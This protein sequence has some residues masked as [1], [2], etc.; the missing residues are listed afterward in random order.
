LDRS[1]RTLSASAGVGTTA[2][3]RSSLGRSSSRRAG[4]VTG[5]TRRSSRL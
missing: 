2:R 3:S 5:R 1:R 4:T